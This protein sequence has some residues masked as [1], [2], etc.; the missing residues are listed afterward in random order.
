MQPLFRLVAAL[1]AVAG[2]G[3]GLRRTVDQ[4]WTCDDA[5]ISFRYAENL[6]LGHGLVFNAGERVEGYTNFAWTML[7]ALGMQLGVDPVVLTRWAGFA[8]FLATLGLLLAASRRVSGG[9]SWLPIAAIALALNPHAQ[10]FATCGL[11]TSL[12]T[13]LVTLLL[14][15][16]AWARSPLAFAA[17]GAVG[18]LAAMTRPDGLLPCAIAGTYA[19][20][21]AARGRLPWS[22]VLAMALP[23]V[24]VYLPYFAWKWWYYGYPLPNTFYAK[25][26]VAPYL[27]QGL[28]YLWLFFRCYSGLAL[29]AALVVVAALA[30]RGRPGE[31]DAGRGADALPQLTLAFAGGYLAFVAWVGGDFMFGRFVMPVAPAL[32]LGFELVRRRWP[33][34]PLGLVLAAAAVAGTVWRA[35]PEQLRDRGEISGIVEEPTYYPREEVAH[36]R[37]CAERLRALY[38]D[39]ESRLA[40]GGAQAMI[41]YY[42]KFD[43]VIE[44]STGLTD[45][46]LAHMP[47]AER[48]RIGHEKNVLEV[49]PGYVERRRVQLWIDTRTPDPPAADYPY[50]DFGDFWGRIVTWDRDLM[51]SWKGA[52]G[53]SFVDCEAY[54]DEELL[55]KLP[56]LPTA[57]VEKLWQALL[58][59]YFT[60]NDDPVR[61]APFRERLGL[62]AR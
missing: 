6:L 21:R 30:C 3:I 61:E 17:A 51:R 12:F 37:R 29:G 7:V 24:V 28:L 9:A 1:A 40:I 36:K 15:L 60:P 52:P 59:Y 53:V 25:S 4:F 11:E 47:I 14:L 44:C 33:A 2:V 18:T 20:L 27:G 38:G 13:L 10:L 43:L 39:H 22:R 16:A 8:C 26:A 34:L 41:A 56:K 46:H 23:G 5:F 19:L 57:E 49:D 54:L 50:I 45:A 48:T 62:P 55:P 31:E 35:F 32:Y 58:P 42:G